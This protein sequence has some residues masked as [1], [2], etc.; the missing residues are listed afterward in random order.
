MRGGEHKGAWHRASDSRSCWL[1]CFPIV[2]VL[3]CAC[4]Q[5]NKERPSPFR[6]VVSDS[7]VVQ[8]I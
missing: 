1:Q 5:E 2:V 3:C 7:S 4:I 6:P 8:T